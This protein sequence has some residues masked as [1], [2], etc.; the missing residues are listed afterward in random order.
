MATK[1]TR[2]NWKH[3]E[4]VGVTLVGGERQTVKL[5]VWTFERLVGIRLNGERVEHPNGNILDVTSFD[6]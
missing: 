4:R 5:V 3:G 2:A 6:R 1:I